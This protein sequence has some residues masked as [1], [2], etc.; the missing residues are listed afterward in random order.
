MLLCE[1]AGLQVY[2]FTSHGGHLKQAILLR[3]VNGDRVTEIMLG[4]VAISQK[5]KQN[6]L[7]RRI[8]GDVVV[9]HESDPN[10]A[11]DESLLVYIVV[12]LDMESQRHRREASNANI[13]RTGARAKRS[14]SESPHPELFDSFFQPNSI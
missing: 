3:G 8:V 12:T 7:L 2:A 11:Y 5:S 10:A 4:V 1:Q 9:K 13:Q 6:E 14:R